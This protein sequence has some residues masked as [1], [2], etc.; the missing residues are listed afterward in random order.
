MTKYEIIKT[1]ND[2]KFKRV[3]GI[4]RVLFETFVGIL[5]FSLNEKHK[6]GGRKPKLSVENILL[7]YLTYY[8]DYSTFFSLGSSFGIDESNAYRWIKWCE[9]II[10]TS[11]LS[12][13][14][15][16]TDITKINVAHE[17]L[18][19]VTECSIQRPSNQEIQREYYSGK[20]KKHTIKI[21]VIMDEITK[22]IKGIA[23]DKGSVHDF[24][25]FKNSTKKLDKTIPFLADNGYIGIQEIFQ[26]SLTPKKKSKY[27][28]LS[29]KDKEFNKLISNIRIAVEHINCQLKIFRILAERYRSRIETFYL[30]AL[31]ICCFYNICL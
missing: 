31:I 20:K 7:L 6:K 11:F 10:S 12:M 23:F 26:K 25:L 8:R 22:E 30:R 3:T 16:I 28:P 13:I 9:E 1:Y 5:N 24:K 27:N 18:V 17:H 21:Q 19:D 2:K 15:E 14:N 4:P 29:D